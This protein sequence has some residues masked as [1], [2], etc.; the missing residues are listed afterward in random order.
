MNTLPNTMIGRAR[1]RLS[2]RVAR[3]EGIAEGTFGRPGSEVLVTRTPR[4]TFTRARPGG[5]STGSSA[6][7]EPPRWG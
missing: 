7:S 4:G 2:S 6:N 3:L 1:G 5:N